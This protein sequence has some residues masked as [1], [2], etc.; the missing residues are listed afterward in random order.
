MQF[1]GPCL[2]GRDAETAILTTLAV[3]AARGT[4]QAAFIVGEAGAGKT[5]LLRC[6]A[7]D[8]EGAASRRCGD[9]L[10]NWRRIARSR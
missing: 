9:L 3:R 10:R 8:A 7:A 6:A 1:L 2:V 5:A 4:G